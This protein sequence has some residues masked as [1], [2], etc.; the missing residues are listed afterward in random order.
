MKY[1][2]FQITGRDEA[3]HEPKGRANSPLRAAGCNHDFLPRKGRRARSDAP[4]LGPL[5]PGPDAGLILDVEVEAFH[6]PAHRSADAH[7]RGAISPARELAD[8][9]IRAPT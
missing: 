6:T 8:V 3:F 9:G 4:Y 5:V 2:A 1:A 7:V